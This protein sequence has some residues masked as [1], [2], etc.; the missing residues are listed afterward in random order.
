M[1]RLLIIIAA[2]I[3]ISACTY[4]DTNNSN[5]EFIS[6]DRKKDLSSYNSFAWLPKDSSAIK[7]P[8][9]DHD[10]LSQK[11]HD[12]VN[13]QMTGKGYSIDTNTPDL[14]IQYTFVV[15]NKE[16]IIN[17]PARP[18]YL[19][20]S[21]YVFNEPYNSNATDSPSNLYFYSNPSNIYNY[22]Y[23]INSY[24]YYSPYGFPNPVPQ[25]YGN[26]FQ[27]IQFKEGTLIIDIIDRNKNQLVWRGWNTETLS[28]PNNYQDQLSAEIYN[29]MENFPMKK[30]NEGQ[31]QTDSKK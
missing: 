6:T 21:P 7:D 29:I 13:Q 8:L 27:Q 25:T 20:T 26:T 19:P 2:I 28:D 17:S 14:L 15:E 23:H 4:T 11:I 16:Q 9:Y 12:H 1:K 31:S 10:I 24:P 3:T 22:N 5:A 18:N 30:K